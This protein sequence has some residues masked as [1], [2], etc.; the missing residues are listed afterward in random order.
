MKKNKIFS[1]LLKILGII[2]I[3]F[4]IFLIIY[5][6]I[7][8]Y[9]SGKTSKEALD[10]L[11]TVIT[12]NKSDNNSFDVNN[13][14]PTIEVNGYE[15]IGVISIETVDIKLP[16]LKEYTIKNLSVAPAL[17]KGNIYKNNAII[18][19]HNTKSHFNR[20]KKLN[21]GDLVTF[22]DIN[23]NIFEY[24]VVSTEIISEKNIDLMVQGDWD[25]TLFTCDSNNRFRS[26]IRL[27]KI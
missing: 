21:I 1:T 10:E 17:Y 27:K 7:F 19:A 8:D 3:A 18:I 9:I 25:L 5:N 12:G 15:Y 14:M 4:S 6:L 23:G 16:V 2:L 22:E 26:T 20:I 11:N 13:D 24:E